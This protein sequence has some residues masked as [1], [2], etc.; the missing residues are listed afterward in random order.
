KR[1]G[2][3]RDQAG[4]DLRLTLRHVERQIMPSLEVSDLEGG[5]GA[6]L[7]EV[8]DLIVEV[9]DPGTPIVQVHRGSCSA[10]LVDIAHYRP[11]FST[12]AGTREP[13]WSPPRA[14]PP[15]DGPQGGD[16]PGRQ[17]TRG[18]DG[19]VA[20]GDGAKRRPPQALHAMPERLAVA[21]DLVLA[22]LREAE[23]DA[24]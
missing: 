8:E 18:A 23:P 20:E 22:A 21:L 3:C 24:A 5:L 15:R 1:T 13:G 17:G 12:G 16:L 11:M 19:Q 14:R 7:E 10:S 2:V 9:I 4:D 6:L